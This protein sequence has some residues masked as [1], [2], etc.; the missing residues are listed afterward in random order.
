MTVR[1]ISYFTAEIPNAAGEGFRVLAQLRAAGVNLQ[2]Y[3]GFPDG[4]KSQLDFV[5]D[6]P[7]RFKSAARKLKLKVS[8]KKIAFLL[9][10]NDKVGALTSTL[11]K[12][13][14]ARIN[15]TALTAV[16]AGRRRF[17]AIFWVKQKS[18]PAAAKLL[19]AK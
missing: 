1:K 14:K 5:P 18:V 11:S 15:V 6:E 9:Q 10:G 12:L 13:A 8:D 7:A 4:R 19:R 2:A 3:S 16:T 17:G